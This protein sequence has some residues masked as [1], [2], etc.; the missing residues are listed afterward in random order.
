M[1]EIA[2]YISIVTALY[3]MPNVLKRR[4]ISSIDYVRAITFMYGSKM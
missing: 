1:I 4:S 3:L 2:L